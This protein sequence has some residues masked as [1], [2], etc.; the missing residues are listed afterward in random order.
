[1]LDLVASGPGLG[2]RLLRSLK[3][4]GEFGRLGLVTLLQGLTLVGGILERL[5][6]FGHPRLILAVGDLFSLYINSRFACPR[7]LLG[8]DKGTLEGHELGSVAY[9]HIHS[10]T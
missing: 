7:L 4:L 5:L 10:N 6:H 3:S 1:M 2:P 9:N 8:L